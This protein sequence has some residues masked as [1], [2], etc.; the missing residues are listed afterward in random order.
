MKRI[1]LSLLCLTALS[2]SAFA[3]D[4]HNAAAADNSARNERD[5]SG[6][7]KTSFDRGNNKADTDTTAAIRRA[8]V[9]DDTLGMT[10]KNI[11]II[12]E[13]G[14]VTLRGPVK[15]DS[16]K[17]RIAELAQRA[18]GHSK[19]DNQLEVKTSE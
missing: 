15:S 11:K 8:I 12:T 14:V 19:V 6:E 16:E 1:T 3:Q 13:N 5:R 2:I 17:A 7:N 18:A 4:E 9:G 10:A